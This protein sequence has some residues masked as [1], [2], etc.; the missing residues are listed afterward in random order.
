MSGTP[1]DTGAVTVKRRYKKKKTEDPT[2][3]S[4]GLKTEAIQKQKRPHLMTEA[5]KEAFRKCQEARK[6]L[7]EKKRTA[8]S[9]PPD[10]PLPSEIPS[11]S[12]E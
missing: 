9:T 12:S 3:P 1:E 5:R 10:P 4:V 11:T 2:E 6:A 7:L 8:L